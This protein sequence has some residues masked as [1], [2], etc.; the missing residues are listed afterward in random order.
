MPGD[1]SA[2]VPPE[3]QG[4]FYLRR[5]ASRLCF[6]GLDDRGGRGGAASP[7]SPSPPSSRPSRRL[8]TTC[9][10]Q[11]QRYMPAA[12]N[13]L[14]VRQGARPRAGRRDAPARHAGP[15]GSVRPAAR[16]SAARV[17]RATAA[18]RS[19]S[20]ALAQA[21]GSDA[22]DG[23]ER[24]SS[25]QAVARGRRQRTPTSTRW[26]TSTRAA[27]Q[28][29]GHRDRR[30][31]RSRRPFDAAAQLLVLGQ[32]VGKLELDRREVPWLRGSWTGL[33]LTP[34]RPTRGATCRAGLWTSLVA[35]SHLL[36]LRKNART[37]AAP[38]SAR[39]WRRR[40]RPTIDHERWRARWLRPRQRFVCSL[41]AD[42]LD[43]TGA[44]LA[45]GSPAARCS[46]ST[47]LDLAAS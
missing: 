42:G 36:A 22:R 18:N 21:L 30:A 26:S 31:R 1:V 6:V 44:G 32:L 39:C 23:A 29:P 7:G 46:W 28:R 43:I 3:W 19:S 12:G 14:V 41:G 16:P 2:G 8:S 40:R 5:A 27:R 24:C 13:T 17:A 38:A 4:R 11:S 9:R 10:S 33:D 35:L 34:F 15:A 25:C 45:A 47:C 37:R 20:A